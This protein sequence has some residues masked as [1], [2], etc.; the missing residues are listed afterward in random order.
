MKKMAKK[1]AVKKPAGKKPMPFMATE[2]PEE[3]AME[4]PFIPARK[5]PAPMVKPKAK[6]NPKQSGARKKTTGY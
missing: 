1:S 4:M 6:K 2:S 3:E 5:A